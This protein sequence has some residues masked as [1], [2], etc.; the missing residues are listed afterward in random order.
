MRA[1][2]SQRLLVTLAV[3][4]LCVSACGTTTPTPSTPTSSAPAASSPAATQS[5]AGPG[6][7][8][9]CDLA[10]LIPCEQQAAFLTIPIADS[11]A[12]LTWSSQWAAGRTDRSGWDANSLG[13]G[14]WSL[15]VVQRYQASGHALIGGDGSWRFADG[16]K[17][18]SG[19]LAV[20][21]YDGSLAYIFDAAGRHVST[22]D[23]LLGTTLLTIKYDDNGRL[24]SVDGSESGHPVHLAVVRGSDGT[25]Q[26]LTG[27]DGAQTTI[28]L[29]STGRLTAVTDPAGQTTSFAWGPGDLVTSETNALGGVQRFTYDQDGLL[30]GSSDADGVTDQ[31]A[32]TA[33]PTSVEIDETSALGRVTKERTATTAA[34]TVRTLVQPGGATTTETT[35]ADGSISLVTPDGTKRTIGAQPSLAWGLQAP[36]LTPDVSQRPDGVT[37]KMEVAEALKEVG[38][39]PYQLSGTIT[40]TT[41]GAASV[42]TPDPASRHVTLVDAAGRTSAWTL[43]AAGRVVSQSVPAS[44]PAAFAYDA[45]GRESSVTVGS[46]STALVTS[47]AYDP[48]TGLVTESRPD[49]SKTSFSVDAQGNVVESS[50][51]DGSTVVGAYNATGTMTQ[52]QPPGGLSTTLGYSAAGRPTL[53]LPPAAGND[54]SAETRTYDADGQPASI[55]LPGGQAVKVTSDVSGQPASWTVDGGTATATYDPTTGLETSSSDPDGVTT[56]YAYTGAATTG[57]SWTGPVHGSVA[58]SLD[59]NG[60]QVA[61]TVNGAAGDTRTYDAAGSL[62]GIDGLAISRDPTSGLVTGSTLG[63]VGTAAS[64]NESAQLAHSAA[65]VSGTSVL[66]DQYTRDALGRISSISEKTPTGT[67]TTAYTYDGSDRLASVTVDG[68]VVERDSYDAAGNR[69]SIA[70]PGGTTSATYDARN[71]LETW[72]NQTYTWTPNGTLASVKGPAGTTTFDYDELGNLRSVKLPSGTTIGYVV[73][74][75][76]RRIGRELGGQLAAGYLYDP[77]G[78]IVATTDPSGSVTARFAYDDQGHLALAEKDG[79]TYRVIT[80][81]VGSPRL[82]IDSTSGAVAEALEYDPWGR[83]T[84]DTAPGFIPFGFAGGLVDPDTGLVQ[85]GARDYD[86]VTGRWTAADPIT[87]AGGDADLYR[88]VGDD[89]VNR[90]DPAGLGCGAP[91][92]GGIILAWLAAPPLA[93]VA[94]ALPCP[95]DEPSPSPPPPAPPSGSQCS[96][97]ACRG[98]GSFHRRQGCDVLLGSCNDGPNGIYNCHGLVCFGPNGS[99]CIWA[100][101]PMATPTSRPVMAPTTTFRRPAS[102][103]RRPPAGDRF[104]SRPGSRRSSAAP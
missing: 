55:S 84:A 58:I 9:A 19:G 76:G 50:T 52:L 10:G 104:R 21:T 92:L 46:G 16:V 89:A 6:P 40:T 80:D 44:A 87:F 57:L 45:N 5:A 99:G 38:G 64:S 35:A 32:R 14:G 12:A 98:P 96:A 90:S 93:L 13:L 34:G 8:E 63:V 31:Y 39:L 15:D 74:A 102:S 11:G 36:I 53:F 70:T 85:F 82:V 75:D 71:R 42:E 7:L 20:P 47:Y 59:P 22:V 100:T 79:R 4:G 61:S 30:V 27:I 3:L 43:D 18:A 48:Q 1:R 72:G 29:D 23:G 62:T 2:N 101:A 26:A 60:R 66:D 86:P 49:G 28:Q 81:P 69:T 17:L 51:A 88:Y 94:G 97:L 33:T 67:A 65:T 25:V 24:Q 103:S 41:N 95:P 68:K 54:T 37:S 83:I 91:Q 56:A 77:A 73:D 78:Q